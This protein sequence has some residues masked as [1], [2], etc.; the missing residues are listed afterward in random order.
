[1]TA[2]DDNDDLPDIF[3]KLK[4]H[5]L[6]EA[7]DGSTF[8]QAVQC[9]ATK[10]SFKSAS[11][12]MKRSTSTP[13]T[14]PIEKITNPTTPPPTLPTPD[15]TPPEKSALAHIPEIADRYVPRTSTAEGI[16]YT[17]LR[18]FCLKP[19]FWRRWSSKTY[20]D[21][22]ETLR[23]QFDPI[24]FAREHC[25]PVEEVRAVFSAL[26]CNPLYDAKEARRRGEDGVEEMMALY[27]RFGTPRRPWGGKVWGELD[28]V[29]KGVVRL[30][31][32]DGSK[33]QVGVGELSEL[34]VK[35]LQDTLAENDASML[36]GD[37]RPG[38]E[39]SRVGWRG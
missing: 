24:P 16:D 9:T 18:L 38:R 10:P 5:S 11:T 6:R 4:T 25:M 3:L 29:E 7:N 21:F 34:D 27:N 26:V 28:G 17:N 35:Y 13:P 23:L 1:M 12:P 15:A 39:R 14:S 19:P 32:A 37:R 2:D 22:A 36:W 30:V 8:A 31:C 20:L 33:G